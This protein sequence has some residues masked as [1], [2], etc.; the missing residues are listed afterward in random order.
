MRTPRTHCRWAVALAGLSI[1]VGSCTTHD[2]HSQAHSAPE[3]QSDPE[4]QST[5]QAQSQAQSVPAPAGV[6]P[7][8]GGSSPSRFDPSA[9]LSPLSADPI[10]LLSRTQII[11][12]GNVV[13]DPAYG[14]R[15]RRVTNAADGHGG[16]MRHEYSRRQ[17]FNADNTRLLAQDGSGHWFVYDVTTSSVVS[18]LDALAGDCE[19]LWDPTAPHA[20]YFTSTN[21]G[22]VWWRLDTRTGKS[23]VAFDLSNDLPWPGATALW[24]KGEGTLSADGRYLALMATHYDAGS[25]QN[26]VFGLVTVDLAEGRLVAT[27]DARDFP[28]PGA[29]PDHVS[30]SPSGMFVVPSWLGGQ[31]GTWAYSRDLRDARQLTDSSE[32][33]DLALDAQGRDVLV[34]ADYAAGAITAVGLEDGTRTELHPLY[35]VEGDAYAV[36]IS[37]Q[38]VERPGWVVVSTYA[39]TSDYGRISPARTAQPEY[40]KVWLLEVAPRGRAFNVAHV[41]AHEHATLGAP[42]ADSYSDPYFLEPQA[43]VSRD[44]SRIVF[45]SN[46]GEA[47]VESYVVELP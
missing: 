5:A 25:Q 22:L 16:R 7:L 28:T 43:S 15:I 27:L 30:I 3:A 21:G 32:H 44:L 23:T 6:P 13:A 12:A 26:M 20:L 33:S 1:L 38:A 17:A 4:A 9:F 11:A 46:M 8:S 14:T 41:H 42:E 31:G 40:R 36:H 47:A 18:R 45:A 24:T 29:F 34:Y 37:G 39:D 19:P 10:P 2:P 35:P